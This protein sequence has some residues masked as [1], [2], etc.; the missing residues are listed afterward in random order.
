VERIGKIGN[1]FR[2]KEGIQIKKLKEG[3]L[4]PER[5][6]DLSCRHSLSLEKAAPM[7]AKGL[8]TTRESSKEKGDLAGVPVAQG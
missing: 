2:L 3:G 6:N 5:E 4:E 8:N 1:C 7:D